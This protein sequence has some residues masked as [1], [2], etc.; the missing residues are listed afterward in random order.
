M[1]SSYE[2]D[3]MI[4][5]EISILG[6]EGTCKASQG[7]DYNHGNPETSE[8]GEGGILGVLGRAGLGCG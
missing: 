1:M 6:V 4:F 8:F 2:G 5:H 7:S 3:E